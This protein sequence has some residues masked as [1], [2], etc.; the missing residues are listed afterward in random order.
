MQDSLEATIVTEPDSL[1]MDHRMDQRALEGRSIIITRQKSQA[2]NM[3]AILENAG[4][5]I[6]YCPTIEVVPPDSWSGVD[7]AIRRIGVYDWIVFTSANGVRFFLERM[8]ESG[9]DISI[10]NSLTCCA[11]GPATAAALQTGGA[12]VDVIAGD[13]R[14]EGVIEAVISRSGGR[15][16]IKG[17]RFLI[18]RAQVAR[19]LLPTEIRKLGGIV[20]AVDVYKTIKPDLDSQA[21]TRMLEER[22]VDAVTFTSPSTVAH[23]ADALARR[24]LVGLLGGVLIGCIGPVTAAAARQHGLELIVQPESHNGEALARAIIDALGRQPGPK[25][26]AT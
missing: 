9:L 16:K 22:Q 12:R 6:I 15:G 21:I 26:Q 3:A 11:I 4:A 25:M 7:E 19:D 17:L 13:A 18:P 23:F 10:M 20:D 14:A 8:G 5:R 1:P 2:V 24:D